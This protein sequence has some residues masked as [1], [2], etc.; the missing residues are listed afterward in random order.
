[1]D[2][3]AQTKQ[4]LSD[5]YSS[6]DK[7]VAA[8]YAKFVEQADTHYKELIRIIKNKNISLD[9]C[10]LGYAKSIGLLEKAPLASAVLDTFS[11]IFDLNAIRVILTSPHK[12][13]IV[14][15]GAYHTGSIYSSLYKLNAFPSYSVEFE[16]GRSGELAVDRIWQSLVIQERSRMRMYAPAAIGA[17]AVFTFCYL[18]FSAIVQTMVGNGM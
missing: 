6:Q 5:Y 14:V 10:V 12:N 16:N 2:E 11:P 7:T 8:L 17:V 3:F 4:M 13:M 15:A 18:F 9:T 1:M